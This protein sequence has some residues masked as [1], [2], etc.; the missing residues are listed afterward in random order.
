MA[1]ISID[2]DT[3]YD[4]DRANIRDLEV[5][6]RP[7]PYHVY[8]RKVRQWVLDDGKVLDLKKRILNQL[9]EDLREKT[10]LLNLTAEQKSDAETDYNNKLNI[11]S[12]VNDPVILQELLI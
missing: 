4:G 6:V 11:L 2:T 3:Y 12:T 9:D 5:P 8:N 1:F 7:T 10:V